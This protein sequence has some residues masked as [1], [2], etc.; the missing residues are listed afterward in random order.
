MP[1]KTKFT[2][3]RRKALPIGVACEKI[4]IDR[5]TYYL[6]KNRA[7]RYNPLDKDTRADKPYHDFFQKVRQARAGAFQQL[8]NEIMQMGMG[9]E[10]T[11][12]IE[13]YHEKEGKIVGQ[14]KIR[15]LTRSV[16]HPQSLIFLAERLFPAYFANRL[17]LDVEGIDELIL[18]ELLRL[19]RR[20]ESR[21]SERTP[22]ESL[23]QPG[24]DLAGAPEPDQPQDWENLPPQ[25][26][27]SN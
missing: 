27:G 22:Q 15:V 24:A 25:L 4:G 13:E 2:P 21:L 7:E 8:L 11:E 20:G 14:K 23:P 5:T 17:R 19:D 26:P 6:W 3:A 18:R 12:K 9:Y 16:R 1:N 10:T